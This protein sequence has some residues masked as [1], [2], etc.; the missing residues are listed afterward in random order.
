MK[1]YPTAVDQFRLSDRQ[2]DAISDWPTVDHVWHFGATAFL[3]WQLCTVG[4]GIFKMANVNN[5]LL[6]N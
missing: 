3:L 5:F 6:V 2:T 1:E 4:H